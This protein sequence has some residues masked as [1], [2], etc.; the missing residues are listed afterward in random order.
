MHERKT[1]MYESSSAF[2]IMPGGLGTLEEACEILTWKQL[3]LHRKKI[4]FLDTDKFSKPFFDLLSHLVTTQF[5][6]K[7]SLSSFNIAKNS[8]E[9][10][11]I[12][13]DSNRKA[14]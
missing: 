4:I 6:E 13:L 2:V 14:S 12:L 1:T 5:L 7:Q 11:S 8:Q 9:V 3:G 10:V